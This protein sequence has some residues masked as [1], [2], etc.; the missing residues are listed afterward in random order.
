MGVWSF[1]SHKN[2]K[3]IRNQSH[4]APANILDL[5]VAADIPEA[6]GMEV[7]RLK[8]ASSAANLT[9]KN[10]LLL[11]L[12]LGSTSTLSQIFPT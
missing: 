2:H 4:G 12:P 9:G 5:Y 6:E 3:I 7:P 8:F 10:S 1:W 11:K